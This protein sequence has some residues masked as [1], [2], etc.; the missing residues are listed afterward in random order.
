M[1]ATDNN[2]AKKQ[3]ESYEE[4]KK[5]Q[6]DEKIR[7]EAFFLQKKFDLVPKI[8]LSF[9]IELCVIFIY[10]VQNISCRDLLSG[11]MQFYSWAILTG[12]F[13]YYSKLGYS[14]MKTFY[15]MVKDTKGEATE[16]NTAPHAPKDEFMILYA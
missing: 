15:D 3:E 4:R 8:V 7:K 12:Y 6:E 10:T 14:F 1:E 5:K 13:F 9:I 11:R 16:L 2:L